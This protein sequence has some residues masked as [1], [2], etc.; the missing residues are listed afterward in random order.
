MAKKKSLGSLFVSGLI[1]VVM[2][3]ISAV[4]AGIIV[5]PV[6]WLSLELSFPAWVSLS[7]SIFVT[8]IVLGWVFSNIKIRR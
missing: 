7:V 8:I 5:I 1:I 3:I 4:M 6:S 2:L